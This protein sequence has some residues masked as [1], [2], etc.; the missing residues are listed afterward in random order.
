MMLDNCYVL[1]NFAR[2]M[3]RAVQPTKTNVVP[4]KD[5]CTNKQEARDTPHIPL[6]NN[7]H[8]N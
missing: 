4:P 3:T 6:T 8:Q 5:Q 2:H 1:F 7:G